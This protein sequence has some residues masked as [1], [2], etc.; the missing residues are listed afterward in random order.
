[1]PICCRRP[2]MCRPR[3]WPAFAAEAERLVRGR[4]RAGGRS[5]R[6][7][8]RGCRARQHRPRSRRHA[9]DRRRSGG[10]RLRGCLAGGDVASVRSRSTGR[11]GGEA[12][13]TIRWHYLPDHPSY[14]EEVRVVTDLASIELEFP[15]PYLLNAPT[16]LRVAPARRRR[17]DRYV[18]PLRQGI[19]RAGAAGLPRA[20]GRWNCTEGRPRRGAR[21]HRDV[22][23]DRGTAR[24]A[25]WPRDHDRVGRRRRTQYGHRSLSRKAPTI[26]DGLS[27]VDWQSTS[28]G[29]GCGE[30]GP[31]C[32]RRGSVDSESRR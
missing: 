1:M 7:A 5:T 18:L 24:G 30:V 10:D 19:V 32:A 13:F 17:S 28:F 23:A 31:E 22:A 27:G 8:L 20:G 4:P 14:R 9:R 29:S 21:R 12:R 2:V 25:A 3:R 6:A 15:S 16:V 11:L 26:D